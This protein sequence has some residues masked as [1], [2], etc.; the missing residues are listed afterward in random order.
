MLEVHGKS[1]TNFMEKA[2]FWVGLSENRFGQG[3]ASQ[4]R[5]Q[6]M[7]GLVFIAH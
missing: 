2:T 4:E 6:R 3:V 1:D 5:P 7:V